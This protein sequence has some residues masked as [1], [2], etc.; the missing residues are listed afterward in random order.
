MGKVKRH[1]EG[2]RSFSNYKRMHWVVCKIQKEKRILRYFQERSRE[3][4]GWQGGCISQGRLGT[5]SK[6][7]CYVSVLIFIASIGGCTVQIHIVCT[8][9]E[10]G[11]NFKARK[12]HKSRLF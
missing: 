12:A 7:N 1:L 3:E 11:M 4:S 10:K 6:V 8:L 2:E 5:F 9:R